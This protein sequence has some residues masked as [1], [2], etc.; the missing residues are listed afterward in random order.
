MANISYQKRT[1]R[2]NISSYDRS[3]DYSIFDAYDRPSAAKV[4]AWNDCKALCYECGGYGLKVINHN[5]FTFTAGFESVDIDTGV[6][7]FHYITP[8]YHIAV[9]A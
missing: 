2:G 5:T 3:T 7:M 9:E 8:N 4:A 1:A 6:V